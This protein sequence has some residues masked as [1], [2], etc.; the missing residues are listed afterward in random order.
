MVVGTCSIAS[1]ICSIGRPLP[2]AHALR[3]PEFKLSNGSRCGPDDSM[4]CE[5]GIDRLV[6]RPHCS[7]PWRMVET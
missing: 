5:E 6:P 7:P 2:T 1:F 3:F 4:S